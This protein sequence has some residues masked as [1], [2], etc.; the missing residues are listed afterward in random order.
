M[1]ES[2]G[3]DHRIVGDRTLAA[4]FG[5]YGEQTPV[6]YQEDGVPVWIIYTPDEVTPAALQEIRKYQIGWIA[7]DLRAAD[8]FPLTGFY[9]DESEPGA[10][11][12]TRLTV[13]GL[14]KFTGPGFRRA[15]DN[16]NVVLFEVV[17]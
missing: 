9:F 12:D 5:S 16:G 11:V 14:T 6:T 1:A 2:Q 15:Y 7:A 4:V 17:S 13:R 8:Q 10:Y 3:S